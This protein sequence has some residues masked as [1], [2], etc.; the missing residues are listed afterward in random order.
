VEEVDNPPVFAS[1][2]P[3]SVDE[4]SLLTIQLNAADPDGGAV[5]YRFL[6]D[7]PP[8]LT[9]DE[10]TGL[11]RWTPDETQGP[12]SYP[13]VLRATEV[14]GAGQSVQTTFSILVREVNSTPTLEPWPAL[15]RQEGDAIQL[16]AR[17]TDADEPSQTLTFSLEGQV[18]GVAT[19]D[20]FSGVLRW[21]LPDDL[22]RTNLSLVVKVTDDAT[23]PRSTAQLLSVAVMPKFRVRITEVMNRPT[24]VGG[25][26]IELLNPSAL[27]AWDL[28]G[29]RLV[30]RRLAFTMPAGTVLAPGAMLCV[31]ADT[32]AF[33]TAYGSVPLA[34]AW[35]GTLDT[36]SDDLRLLGAQ[37]EWLH[38]VVIRT[39]TPWPQPAPNAGVSLQLIDSA[40]A[41]AAAGNWT[42][43]SFPRQPVAYTSTWRYLDTSAPAGTWMG[44]GYDDRAWKVGAGLL[45]WE[46]AALPAPKTTPLTLGQLAYY[47]RT[48]FIL[49]AVPAGATLALSHIID[50]AAVFYLN[51]TELARFN[52]NPGTAMTPTTLANV[53]VG[54]GVVVGPASVSAQSLR[55]GTN[56]L[57]VEVHQINST[58]SDVVMGLQLDLAGTVL[59]ATPGAPNNVATTLAPFP[60][61]FLNELAPIPGPLHD[62]AGD[63][64]PWVE[65]LNA[66]DTDQPLAG[67]T[68]TSSTG[69]AWTFPSSGVLP[70]G[71]RRIV[72]LDGELAE[73][74]DSEWHASFRPA[75][76]NGW[77]A[78]VRPSG[79]GSGIVDSVNYASAVPDTTW[80]CVPEGQSWDRQWTPPTPALPNPAPPL[81]P[82]A[83]TATWS[84]VELVLQWAGEQQVRYRVE[85]A[86]LLSGP[87]VP[88][89]YLVGSGV[90]LQFRDKSPRQP[91]RFYR[92]V[93]E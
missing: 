84:P 58:S 77:L 82:P 38:R 11:I 55:A 22:G 18:P 61:L 54:D 37:G 73:Q 49:P 39:T 21:K 48:E 83:L 12:G 85:A 86:E 80:S 23:P 24:A 36:D 29:A 63:A 41:S 25:A 64:E 26:F 50:D 74:S 8:G 56:T 32:N 44:A 17:A 3:Q 60:S 71:E 40:N 67:W 91:S 16:Q 9:L 78:L 90:P 4:G 20:P 28:S 62:G 45:Y 65:L 13:L 31:A 53:S 33:R 46:D 51:G 19:I 30:G 79:V 7:P 34:G 35:V 5:R 66:G 92:I 69:A 68:L 76:S 10:N 93:V 42:L 2:G 75:S 6:N 1:P 47:F 27:T 59:G 43:A 87:W 15:A 89:A 70:A 14:G 52:F 88:Q 57:A 72:F 81:T